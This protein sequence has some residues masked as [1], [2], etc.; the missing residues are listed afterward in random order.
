VAVQRLSNS[1]RSGFSYKSLI[2][3]ITPLPSVPTIGAA[4]A[5]N[6]SSVN[7][8]FTAPGAYAGST[9]TATSS[10][11]GYTGT[12]ATSPILVEGLSELTEYT[13]TVTATNATGTSGASA[14]SDAV[15]TPVGDTG[16]MFPLGMVQV[17]SAGASTIDFTSIPSTY[18][19]LQIRLIAQK[20]TSSTNGLMRFNGDTTGTNYYAHGIE[21]GASTADAFAT[22]DFPRAVANVPTTANIFAASIVDILDYANTNKYKTVRSLNGVDRNGSG[23]LTYGSGLWKNTNAITSLTI[24]PTSGNFA[25]FSSFA[26]YGI[27]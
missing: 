7:V 10:P 20:L 6:F 27:L 2:A 11:G 5:V 17:G 4:T 1:G 18:K 3:G 12:S 9:Y 23:E 8:A 15:T 24:Y 21:G 25:Q 14:A 26:L 22:N 19:H 13:F 16:V